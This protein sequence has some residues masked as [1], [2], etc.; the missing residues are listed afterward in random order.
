MTSQR[1]TTHYPIFTTVQQ[2]FTTRSNFSLTR[3]L[4]WLTEVVFLTQRECL[5]ENQF[6]TSVATNPHG[7][8][9]GASGSLSGGGY[10]FKRHT[11]QSAVTL[12]IISSREAE[13]DS[14]K[15]EESKLEPRR[16]NSTAL[17]DRLAYVT[18]GTKYALYN[19]SLV[20][21]HFFFIAVANPIYNTTV[22]L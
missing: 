12:V 5:F 14:R 21:G 11:Q 22:A 1:Y 13:L 20:Q 4:F 18:M 8:V 6:E 16:N 3:W 17:L 19:T 9:R 10:G 7:T 15:I 2:Y